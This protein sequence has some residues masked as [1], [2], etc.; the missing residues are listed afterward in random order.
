[1]AFYFAAVGVLA[2]GKR[3]SEQP[4][5]STMPHSPQSHKI[6]VQLEAMLAVLA[7][8]ACGEV[9]RQAVIH[10]A[11]LLLVFRCFGFWVWYFAPPFAVGEDANSKRRSER[12]SKSTMSSSPQ[13]HKI[14]VQLEAMLAV[15]ACA[16]YG[17]VLRQAVGH[18]AVLLL[19]FRCFGIWVWYFALPFA[20]GEEA[21]SGRRR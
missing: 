3:R 16:V 9:L 14:P 21:N 6:P 2:N 13:S 11:V 15:L 5:K 10:G 12:P 4:S 1:L 7:C 17:E 20:V 19:V 8:A 18:G